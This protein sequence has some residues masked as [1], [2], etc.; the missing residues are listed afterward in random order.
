MQYFA[1]RIGF[2]LIASACSVYAQVSATCASGFE[3]AIQPGSIISMQLRSGDIEIAGNDS[4]KLRVS[5]E[6][7]E[8]YEAKDVSISFKT[9][10]KTASLRVHGGPNND[11]RFRVT[12]PKR[13]N[14]IV[15][16]PAGDMTISGVIGD[17]DVDLHAGDLTISVGDPA[18][19]LH[20][21]AA[22]WAG[23][24][25]ASPFGVQKDGLFRSFSKD[26]ANGRYRLHAH[27][28]AGDLTLK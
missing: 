21:D 17:K 27:L 16:S 26:N 24:L 23:D 8:A 18:D 25:I 4:P 14:L 19:Y 5:C 1:S 28:M 3:A 9:N 22:V 11:V 15:R 6:L 10:G 12:V 2:V 13:S 20:A 7:K